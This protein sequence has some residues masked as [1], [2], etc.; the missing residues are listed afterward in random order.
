MHLSVSTALP[1]INNCDDK[2]FYRKVRDKDFPF[3][4][5]DRFSRHYRNNGYSRDYVVDYLYY[6]LGFF[7]PNV[8]NKHLDWMK[9]ML[10]YT[11]IQWVAE[12]NGG[13]TCWMVG[14]DGCS[15]AMGGDDSDRLIWAWNKYDNYHEFFDVNDDVEDNIKLGETV[16]VMISDFY[17]RGHAGIVTGIGETTVETIVEDE[18]EGT[19]EVKTETVPCVDITTSNW[20]KDEC[21]EFDAKNCYQ[22]KG[23]FG[24]PCTMRCVPIN[25]IAVMWNP[26]LKETPEIP[27]D[28]TP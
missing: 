24:L 6:K 16:A 1:G 14:P 15:A 28:C 23:S 21:Q 27:L 2:G 20:R 5:S 19:V 17:Y 25:R 18:D 4:T 13:D 9:S 10:E 8:N 3:Y 12:I 7:D 11:P 22:T 26:E